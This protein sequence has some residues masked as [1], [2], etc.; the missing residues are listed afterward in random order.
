MNQTMSSALIELKNKLKEEK[1]IDFEL[2]V[3]YCVDIYEVDENELIDL[4]RL[5]SR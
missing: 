2:A 5:L 4:F 3:K 1:G